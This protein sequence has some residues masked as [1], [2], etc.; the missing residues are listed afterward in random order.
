MK[1]RRTVFLI[2]GCIFVAFNILAL[3]AVGQNPS[4]DTTLPADAE[5]PVMLGHYVGLNL[6]F[7]IGFIFLFIAYRI[8]RKIKKVA[9]QNLLDSF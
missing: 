9:R 1:T 7:I 8:N 4:P 3:I 5:T 2:L 6:F